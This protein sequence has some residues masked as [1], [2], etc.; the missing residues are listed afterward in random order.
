LSSLPEL[1]YRVVDFDNHYY[2]VDDCFSRHIDPK[3]RDQAIHPLEVPQEDGSRPWV[4]GDRAVQFFG[5]NCAD[6]IAPPG[7]MENRFTDSGE[8]DFVGSSS[9]R[10]W[11]HPEMMRAAP[12]ITLMDK[13]G[14]EAAVMIPTAGLG[15]EEEFRDQVPAVCA[16]LTSFNRWVEEEWGYG[17]DGRIFGVP[18]ISF[19]DLDWAIDEL[20]RVADLGA[21]MVFLKVGP[22]NDQSPADPKFDPWWARAQEMGIRPIFHI[23]AG[24]FTEMYAKHWGEDPNRGIVN[25]S[26]LQVYMCHSER[27]IGDTMAALLLHN[28]F[29]RFP[30]LEVISVENG[31]SWVGSLLEGADKAAN[32]SSGGPWLGGKPTDRPSEVFKQ[33]VYVSPFFEDD[34]GGLIDLIGPERVVFGSDWPHPEGLAEPLHILKYIPELTDDQTRVFMR[35]NGARLL[36]LGGA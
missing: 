25:W 14:L 4:L 12:R 21:K 33:H 7:F 22:V 1:P 15:V 30:D 31:S 34:I 13:Q 5:A 3:F 10:A 29:G 11:D 28:L 35:E 20:D 8:T 19:L 23:G 32:F 24:G 17:A 36:G 9:I 26:A 2:E 6:A 27:P 16:N 18:M